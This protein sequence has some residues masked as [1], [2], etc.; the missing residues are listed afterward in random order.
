MLFTFSNPA[1]QF[2]MPRGHV[3]KVKVH[4]EFEKNNSLPPILK[5]IF[6]PHTFALMARAGVTWHEWPL[7]RQTVCTLL[8]TLVPDGTG[9]FGKKVV[10]MVCVMSVRCLSILF[11]YLR[12]VQLMYFYDFF[13]HNSPLYCYI[14]FYHTVIFYKLLWKVLWDQPNSRLQYCIYLFIFTINMFVVMLKESFINQSWNAYFPEKW[15]FIF[16]IFKKIIYNF[17]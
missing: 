6:L 10:N 4:K 11:L 8:F 15:H 5:T 13:I 12:C 17:L 2:M 1:P 9:H 7:N 16:E 3:S 14:Y